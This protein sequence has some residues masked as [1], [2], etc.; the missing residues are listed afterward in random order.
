MIIWLIGIII[1]FVAI[2]W[3][4]C[5]QSNNTEPDL[6][7]EN[8]WNRYSPRYSPRY[9]YHPRYRFWNNYFKYPYVRYY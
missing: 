7:V 1:L 4:I 2:W 6:S 9:R 3:Y 8:F 5:K